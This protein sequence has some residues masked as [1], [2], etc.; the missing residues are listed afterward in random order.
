MIRKLVAASV[1]T[2]GSAIALNHGQAISGECYGGN[3]PGFGMDS[4]S[5]L[6]SHISDPEGCLNAYN[7]LGTI[8]VALGSGALLLT[9]T[10]PLWGRRY[11]DYPDEPVELPPYLTEELERR[12][13]EAQQAEQDQPHQ[14]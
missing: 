2:I 9:V 11:A 8:G 6:P 13:Q 14:D 7:T 4:V 1:L 10:Q 5:H 12:R 3:P